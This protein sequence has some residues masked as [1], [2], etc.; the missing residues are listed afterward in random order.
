MASR[1]AQWAFAVVYGIVAIIAIWGGVAALNPPAPAPS[2]FDPNPLPPLVNSGMFTAAMFY[3][4][5]GDRCS[6]RRPCVTPC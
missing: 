4:V 1:V 3:F 2:P 5:T 6:R